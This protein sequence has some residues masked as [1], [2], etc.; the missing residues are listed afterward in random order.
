MPDL[1]DFLLYCF[2]NSTFKWKYLGGKKK[3][4]DLSNL[5]IS[6]LETC[7]STA[8]KAMFLEVKNFFSIKT[9]I[10]FPL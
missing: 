7:R 2:Y 1:M 9:S 8:K 4:V 10:G 3:T 6:A 5:A